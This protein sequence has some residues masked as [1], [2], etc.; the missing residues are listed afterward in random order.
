MG[1][2]FDVGVFLAFQSNQGQG[3]HHATIRV[4]GYHQFYA[5]HSVESTI[6]AMLQVH[7]RLV[8]LY[9]RQME[10]SFNVQRLANGTCILT[11]LTDVGLPG[12]LILRPLANRVLRNNYDIG[13]R[14]VSDDYGTQDMA[15]R[16]ASQDNERGVN[17]N[18]DDNGFQ[19]EQQ[20]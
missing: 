10:R 11:V 4:Y 6:G 3:R 13:F 20:R 15:L 7:V 16:I 14:L 18:N 8:F 9:G 1:G 12:G 17:E 2:N 5:N 19:R